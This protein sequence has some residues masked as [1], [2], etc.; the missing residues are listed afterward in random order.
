[1]SS[2]NNTSLE[3]T[4]G[5]SDVDVFFVLTVAFYCILMPLALVGNILVCIAFCTDRYLNQVIGNYLIVSLAVTD[6]LITCVI[7]PC[8]LVTVLMREWIFGDAFCHVYNS[9]NISCSAA[10]ILNLCA[11][12]LD[13]YIR[14]KY[15]LH[16]ELMMTPVTV[17]SI[18][19]C[20]WVIA[21]FLAIV[22][23]YIAD[24]LPTYI[25]VYSAISFFIPCILIMVMYFKLF[26][27][28][29][30]IAKHDICHIIKRKTRKN[31]R[32]AAVTLGITTGV[33]LVCWLPYYTCLV[34]IGLGVPVID[35]K[36][37]IRAG[38]ANAA[39]NP[40][41][42]S[43]FNTEYRRAFVRIL[44]CKNYKPDADFSKSST[45]STVYNKQMMSPCETLCFSEAGTTEIDESMDIELQTISTP[46][47]T[48]RGS[49]ISVKSQS[50]NCSHDY[51]PDATTLK[52][53]RSSPN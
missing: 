47:V 51:D 34:L 5:D 50:D 44:S 46:T 17:G 39:F 40:I 19:L 43:Y 8:N 42:Y 35:L 2:S 37:A 4:G 30:S 1:M 52:S 16:Y 6:L 23:I 15:A 11:I 38:W 45:R 25:F 7:M 10:M 18:I 53:G 26:R 12:S 29:R 14:I 49:V 9:L 24:W 20:A 22:P 31:E 48:H 13:R 41:I 3:T 28:A 36:M 32:K 27:I 21:V 33:F